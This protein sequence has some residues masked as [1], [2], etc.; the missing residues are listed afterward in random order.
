MG[1]SKIWREGE[2]KVGL[3]TNYFFKLFTVL[4]GLLP[5]YF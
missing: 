3:N 2:E 4:F 1:N 5:S